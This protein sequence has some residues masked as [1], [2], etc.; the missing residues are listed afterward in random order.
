MPLKQ[1]W[2]E[3]RTSADGV[4][5]AYVHCFYALAD[6]GAIAFF[7]Y[8][9]LEPVTYAEPQLSASTSALRCDGPTRH[10]IRERLNAAGHTPRITDHGYC[11][12]LYVT[13]PNGLLLE[14]TVDHDDIDAIV[15][16]QAV[17]AH[18]ELERWRSGD[19]QPNNS[20]R[21]H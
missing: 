8:E 17:S 13:D 10:A 19:H 21:P 2:I 14:F 6:G 11:V 16:R 20:L 9:G 5:S 1:T 18:D 3:T 15:A 4:T 7:E 12:S